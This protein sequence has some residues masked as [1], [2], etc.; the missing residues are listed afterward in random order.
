MNFNKNVFLQFM[1]RMSEVHFNEVRTDKD[2]LI[3][4]GEN[5]EV[6]TEVLVEK[7]GDFVAPA[8]G[9][10]TTEDGKVIEVKEGKVVDIKEPQAEEE[11]VTIGAE[12]EVAPAEAEPEKDEKDLRIEELE[13][14][15]ADRDAVIEELTA[16]IKELEDK[17]NAPAAEEVEVKA[18]AQENNNN[19]FKNIFK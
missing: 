11:T 17:A 8:D 7:E 13:G 1:K 18:S 10:Y 19:I 2:V 6:G 9:E 14:L 3:Y 16:K 4:D 5:L 15:L 12:E